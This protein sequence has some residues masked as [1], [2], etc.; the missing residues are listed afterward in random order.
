MFFGLSF[1][2]V[3]IVFTVLCLAVTGQEV[4]ED[5]TEVI[6]IGDAMEISE[7]RFVET[8]EFKVS[9]DG[10]RVVKL[11]YY[12]GNHGRCCWVLGWSVQHRVHLPHH[13]G[14]QEGLQARGGGRE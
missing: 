14:G 1:S 10:G 6:G 5:I 13:G 9:N 12:S 11:I 2:I 8:K 7:E 4:L 3:V